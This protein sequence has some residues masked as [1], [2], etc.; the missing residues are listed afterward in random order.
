MKYILV[1][2][3]GTSS[4]RAIL[5]DTNGQMVHMER[6]KLN[7]LYPDRGIVECDAMEIW[8]KTKEAMQ[9][10]VRNSGVSTDDIL[11]IGMTAQRESAIVW[12][13]DT[14]RPIYNCIVWLDRRTDDYCKALSKNPLNLLRLHMKTGLAITSFFPAVKIAWMLD[15]IPG[16]RDRA[17]KGELCFGTVDTWLFYNMTGKKKFVAEQSNAARTQLFNI[18]KLCWDRDM[19]KM[20]NI[21]MC[22]L[23]EEVLPSDSYFGDAVDIFEKPLPIYG[24]LGDQQAATF[25]QQRFD[26]GDAKITL[27]TSALMSLNIGDRPSGS[28]KLISTIGWNVKGK[29]TYNYE[30]GFYFCGGVFDWLKKLGF[31]KSPEDSEKVASSVETTEGVKF[32]NSFFGLAVPEVVDGAQGLITGLTPNADSRHIV[33]AAMEAVGY[34]IRDIVRLM[35]HESKRLRGNFGVE[36][37]SADGGVSQNRFVMQFAADILGMD[38]TR[39]N[40]TEATAIGAFYI[41]GLA[42]GLFKDLEDIKKIRETPEV[43]RPAMDKKTRDTLYNDWLNT[44]NVSITF[45]KNIGK[46]YIPLS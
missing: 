32:M 42:C 2:D 37:L 9:A 20:F 31:I 18:G 6:R 24:S 16:A 3:E 41:S 22:M 1:V 8:E 34:Q 45:G 28:L 43:Y 17:E 39:C 38:I 29:I 25:G 44:L 36:N 4:T 5:F 12:E 11:S 10:A 14:G 27:G 13:R 19:L 26:L 40:T 33:R 35:N 7:I 46:K 30:T 23:A 21:P 15:N